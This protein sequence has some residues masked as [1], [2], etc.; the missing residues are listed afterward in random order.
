M[1]VEEKIQEGVQVITGINESTQ[2][3]NSPVRLVKNEMVMP[4]MDVDMFIKRRDAMLDFVKRGLV[5]DIDGDYAV[6]P[7]TNKKTLLLPGG[8]KFKIFLGLITRP[9]LAESII[10]P[11]GAKNGGQLPFFYFRYETDI[12]VGDTLITI[13][14]GSANSQEAKWGY[15]WVDIEQ[16]PNKEIP[17]GC[18]TRS[19]K[20]R[21]LL[22][23]IQ[24]AET[25]GQYGKPKEYWE[26]F[27]KALKEGGYSQYTQETKDG[28][29]IMEGIEIGSLQVRVPNDDVSSNVNTIQ[30]IAKKRS[31]LDGIKS[32]SGTSDI[33]TVDMEDTDKDNAWNPFVPNGSVSVSVEKK[34]EN[35]PVPSAPIAQPS[36]ST[37]TAQSAPVASELPQLTPPRALPGSP[38]STGRVAP[39]VPQSLASAVAGKAPSKRVAAEPVGD[40]FTDDSAQQ[41]TEIKAQGTIAAIDPEPVILTKIIGK[42][43]IDILRE[44]YKKARI[45]VNA[46]REFAMNKWKK[47]IAEMNFLQYQ[48]VLRWV[49]N[50]NMTESRSVLIHKQCAAAK[51]S[52]EEVNDYAITQFG[53]QVKHLESDE[54][55]KLDEWIENNQR[56]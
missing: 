19:G 24:A 32:A 40:L 38:Q 55:I 48:E 13:G 39:N 7:G 20:K 22:F 35:S 28:K 29:K 34:V 51:L 4:V 15:K 41:K 12:L 31:E 23:Q 53:K 21:A 11:Y 25:T 26:E 6:I 43:E 16:F 47:G 52:F 49:E 33:F 54:V 5:E 14:H 9:R 8:E 46:L 2:Y 44:A 3:L 45:N 37:P 1:Q 56:T 17:Q 27:K 36:T 18:V 42:P 50:G 30:K 10:D